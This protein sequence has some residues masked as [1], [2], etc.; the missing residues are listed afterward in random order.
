LIFYDKY[1]FV[2]PSTGIRPKI[3]YPAFGLAGYPAKTVS[4]ASLIITILN[5]YQATAIKRKLKP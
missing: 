5:R 2:K 4:G 1:I 3:R